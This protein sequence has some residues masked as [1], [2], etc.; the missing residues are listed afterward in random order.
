MKGELKKQIK[1][2][3]PTDFWLTQRKVLE[4]IEEAKKEFPLHKTWLSEDDYFKDKKTQIMF[5]KE[6]LKWLEK[7]FGDE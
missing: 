2:I 7:W 1:E 6:I 3:K 4:I 5:A